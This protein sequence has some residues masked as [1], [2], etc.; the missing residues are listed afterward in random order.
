MGV[1]V[2][3]AESVSAPAGTGTTITI[4]LPSHQEDDLLIIQ[5]GWKGNQA[6]TT[7]TGWT[8]WFSQATGTATNGC[9]QGVWWRRVNPSET[10]SNP[11]LTIGTTAVERRAIAYC[12]RGADIDNPANTF[13]QKQQTVGNSATP[14]PP[15]ITTLAPNYLLLHLV[16]CRGNSAIT[17]P[18]GY[19]EEQDSAEGTT[20][21]TEGSTKTQAT[22]GSVSGQ[23]A[24]I[25]SNRWVA[26]IIAIP[27][28]DY[29]YFRSQ[30]SQTATATS[31]TGTLPTGTTAADFYGRKDLII[32]TVEAA[33]GSS[34]TVSPN[35]GADWTEIGVWNGNTSGDGT[36]TKKYWAL[37]N[38]SIDLQF[39]RSTSGEI[40]VTLTTYRNPHQTTPIGNSNAKG[41]ASSTTSAWDSQGRSATKSTVQTTC[42]ADATPSYTSPT[43]WTERSDGNGISTADQI[44]EDIG[45]TGSDSFTLSTASP[46]AVGLVEILSHAGAAPSVA[47]FLP[48]RGSFGQDARL[49]R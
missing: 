40:A 20:I 27:S 15:A 11:T 6:P 41:N 34:I 23:A 39:N 30:T 8:L 28:P 18:T 16:T 36:K 38:G 45:T 44:F 10:V 47:E 14:T 33:G 42:I 48:R 2:S 26:A 46:T 12:I 5:A 37:Y 13:Y 7:L 22:A 29:P 17:P 9:G 21:C 4:T 43:G 35:T 32:A 24:S 3:Q 25:S 19:N 31:I 1:P 49:R